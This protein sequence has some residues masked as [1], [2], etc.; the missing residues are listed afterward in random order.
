MAAHS[1][2]PYTL[3]PTAV[4]RPRVVGEVRFATRVLLVVGTPVRRTLETLLAK[5]YLPALDP[6]PKRLPPQAEKPASP[7]LAPEA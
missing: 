1:N 3:K 6:K 2:R 7:N 4:L 5:T